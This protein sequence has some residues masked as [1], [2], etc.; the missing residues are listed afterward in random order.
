MKVNSGAM[1]RARLNAGLSIRGLAETTGIARDT[2][3]RIEAGEQR[4]FPATVKR[5]ADALGVTVLD[6]VVLDDLDQPDQGEKPT[7]AGDDPT[8]AVDTSPAATGVAL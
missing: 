6:L 4:P 2:L 3:T 8:A 5:I 1:Q 7:A